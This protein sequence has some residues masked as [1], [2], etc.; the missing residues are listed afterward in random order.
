VK[1][2]PTKGYGA[3]AATSVLTNM[4]ATQTLR[5]GDGM[6]STPASRRGE[7][8]FGIKATGRSR[9]MK[10]EVIED[11]PNI[12]PAPYVPAQDSSLAAFI[13]LLAARVA[14]DP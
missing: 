12:G 5:A 6:Y 3:T 2:F 7:R 4:L 11:K 9:L 13:R 14:P 1:L 10:F 8:L